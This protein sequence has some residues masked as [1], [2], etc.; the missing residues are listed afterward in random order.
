MICL[1]HSCYLI[2]D[3]IVCNDQRDNLQKSSINAVIS[4]NNRN[5]VGFVC[6]LII[7]Y[8]VMTNITVFKI[9]KSVNYYSD[10]LLLERFCGLLVDLCQAILS[11]RYV[12]LKG[13]RRIIVLDIYQDI[14]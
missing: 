6:V 4:R 8:K 12:M 11:R 2:I 10:F 1:Y 7:P 13:Y 14:L 3:I 9:L 5:N